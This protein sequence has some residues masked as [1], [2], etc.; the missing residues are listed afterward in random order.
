MDKKNHYQETLSRIMYIVIGRAWKRYHGRTQTLSR[1]R[2]M[3][4]HRYKKSL[5]YNIKKRNQVRYPDINFRYRV[6]HKIIIKTDIHNSKSLSCE[7]INRNQWRYQIVIKATNKSLSTQVSTTD[8][9]YHVKHK[10]LST[11]MINHNQSIN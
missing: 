1:W 9:H 6:Y 4:Y 11:K 5:S 8:N 3:H 2:K 7:Y 10:S